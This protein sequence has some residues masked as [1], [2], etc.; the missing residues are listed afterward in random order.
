MHIKTLSEHLK[1]ADD[2]VQ[3]KTLVISLISSLPE[4]YDYYITALDTIGE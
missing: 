4:E 1:V 3:E 2:L